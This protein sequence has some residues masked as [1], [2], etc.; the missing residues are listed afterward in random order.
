MGRKNKK[1]NR[2]N[3][4]IE[5]KQLKEYRILLA[6][7][8][9]EAKQSKMDLEKTKNSFKEDI[10]VSENTSRN[11]A[12]TQEEIGNDNIQLPVKTEDQLFK[13]YIRN[14]TNGYEKQIEISPLMYSDNKGLP[15]F[16]SLEQYTRYNAFA[17]K[18]NTLL[19]RH[20]GNY[21]KSCQEL[22]SYYDEESMEY[23]ILVDI[24][25][26]QNSLDER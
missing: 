20:K 6:K 18:L 1:R 8:R 16:N 12:E 3:P 24:I 7:L 19:E 26:K 15:K 14:A 25:E 2:D 23:K 9:Q 22:K 13:E 4:K 21:L 10:K 17:S 5:R 11:I